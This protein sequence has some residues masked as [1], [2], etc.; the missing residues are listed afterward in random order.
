L[1]LIKERKKLINL[2]PEDILW[3][4]SDGNYISLHT[5]NKKYVIKNSLRQM[6][7]FLDNNKFVRIHKSYAVRIDLIDF[8]NMD[9]SIVSV[10]SMELPLGK[11]FKNDVFNRYIVVK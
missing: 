8:I 4:K 2:Q 3:M 11:R 1:L 9:N 7:S 6:L 5:E 10:N